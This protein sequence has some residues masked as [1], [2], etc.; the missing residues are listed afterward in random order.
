MDEGAQCDSAG[1]LTNRE[2]G[3]KKTAKLGRRK[4]PLKKTSK[5]V[6]KVALKKSKI[7]RKAKGVV[8]GS[9]VSEPLTRYG[10]KSP[11]EINGSH[12]FID[13]FCGIGGFHQAFEKQG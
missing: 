12:R 4:T 3:M 7:H 11:T 1:T 6:H 8:N 13:L 9:A 5:L 10:L 2:R